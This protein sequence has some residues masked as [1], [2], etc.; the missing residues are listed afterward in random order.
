MDPFDRRL[1]EAIQQGLPITPRP[2][3]A[4]AERLGIQE[5]EL[6][7]RLAVLRRQG[8]IKRLGVIVRHRPLGYTA[9]AMIVLDVPDRLVAQIGGHVS[10][11]GFVTLCYRR[12]RHGEQWPYNLYC[13][14]HGKSRGRVLQ[15]FQQLSDSCGLRQFPG[16]VLFSRRCFKQRGALYRSCHGGDRAL[17]I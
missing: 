15:Q 4:I 8:L 7:E 14:I 2:Y 9:N 10:R 17:P 6:I 11:F 12:P 1:L 3:A 16:E 5:A 13:M